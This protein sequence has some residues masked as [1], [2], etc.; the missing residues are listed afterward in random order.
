[1][2]SPTSVRILSVGDYESVRS[3]RGMLLQ[4]GGYSVVSM[5]SVCA[6]GK[7]IPR[8]IKIAVIG[9]TID[10]FSASRIAARLRAEQ[11]N[12]RILRLTKQYSRPGPG[13]DG[14]CFVED[15]PEIFLRCV[16]DLLGSE[17]AEK[18]RQ[19][20]FDCRSIAVLARVGLEP[21]SR[22]SH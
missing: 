21:H 16:A 9:Q 12:I 14:V 10:D 13:F 11:A 18:E 22:V 17:S 20:R 15:G 7:E 2:R 4:Y 8:D 6:L 5:C 3:S 1:V 19:C